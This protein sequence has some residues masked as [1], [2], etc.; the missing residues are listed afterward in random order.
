MILNYHS[1]VLKN[2]LKLSP[3]VR[4]QQFIFLLSVRT[5]ATSQLEAPNTT[6]LTKVTVLVFLKNT[7]MVHNMTL[8]T[9]IVVL[10]AI[11]IIIT[12]DH[13]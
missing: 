13:V 1:L 4:N 5:I 12:S 3:L 2:C 9:I 8:Q 7:C 10:V 6:L 11:T